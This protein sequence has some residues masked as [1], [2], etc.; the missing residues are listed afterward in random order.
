V[1]AAVGGFGF[2]GTGVMSA[3]FDFGAELSWPVPEQY[4][5]GMLNVSGQ[6]LAAAGHE[7]ACQQAALLY[8]NLYRYYYLLVL[9]MDHPR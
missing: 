8:Y 1:A 2:F 5:G 6:V 3:G 9:R 4:S 7:T